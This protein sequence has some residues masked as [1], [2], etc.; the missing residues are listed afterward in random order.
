MDTLARGLDPE[1]KSARPSESDEGAAGAPHVVIVGAGFGGLEATKALARAPVRVTLIDR[2]N[3]HCFQPLLYQVATG[4]LSP[5]DIAWPVRSI[6]S[7]QRNAE[8]LMAEVTGVDTHARA[9]VL[10][11]GRRVAY[12]YLII[13]T[14]A[15]HSYFGHDEWSP[16]APGLKR[17]EDAT[18]IRRRLLLAFERAE[19]EDDE[20]ERRRLMTFIVVGGGPTGVE[21]AGAIAD[22][23]RLTLARDFRR[24]DPRNSRIVLV[25]AGSR[26]LAAFPETSSAYAQ[27][28]LELMGVEVWTTAPVVELDTRGVST[29]QGNLI[30]AATIIWAAGVTASPAA[31]WISAAV[32]RAGRIR[33]ASDL[34]VPGHPE[35]FAIGDTALA[36]GPGGRPAPGVAPA[37][38]QMGRYVGQLIAARVRSRAEPAGFRYRHFGDLATIGRKRAVVS[39]GRL[40]LTGFIAWA[41]WSAAHIFF[42]IGVRNRV[43]VALTWIW[44][45]LTLQRGARLIL[46]ASAE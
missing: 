45:Y 31:A 29:A 35:I 15:T 21:M 18:G 12:D 19:L 14:G 16:V 39:F 32:D 24:I 2:V 10:M 7:R 5:A 34:S 4:T 27:R 33:V 17:I 20:A 38:K 37:A 44:E 8:I 26:V 30:E 28:A 25:E 9:V 22:M 43:V 40:R 46:R 42:L 11:E 3:H 1:L 23:S 36:L 41:F 13:A 6:F